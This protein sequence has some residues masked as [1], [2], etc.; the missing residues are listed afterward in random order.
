MPA[1]RYADR[2]RKT[3]RGRHKKKLRDGKTEKYVKLLVEADGGRF[4]RNTDRQT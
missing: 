4:F 3:D 2:L 1:D